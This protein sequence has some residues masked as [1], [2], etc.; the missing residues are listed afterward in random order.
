MTQNED[1]LT[2]DIIQTA[3]DK[4]MAWWAVESMAPPGAY[5]M[6][7]QLRAVCQ[8]AFNRAMRNALREFLEDSRVRAHFRG[9]EPPTV[10]HLKPAEDTF[11]EVFRRTHEHAVDIPLD[12]MTLVR[13]RQ[14]EVNTARK[15]MGIAIIEFDE[16]RAR[17]EEAQKSLM[18][19]LEPNDAA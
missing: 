4:F 5:G 10:Y 12:S 14:E 3:S 18:K 11:A 15:I 9:R 2:P 8:P 19:L 17:L 13:R 16:A 7:A 1:V 6:I